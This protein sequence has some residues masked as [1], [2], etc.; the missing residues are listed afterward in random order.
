MTLTL[1]QKI[2]TELNGEVTITDVF[3]SLRSQERIFEI[4]G[5]NDYKEL[6]YASELVG[7]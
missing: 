4:T 2:K 6:V 7:D 1:G 3:I 5:K